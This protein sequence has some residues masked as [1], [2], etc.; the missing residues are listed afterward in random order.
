M[1]AKWMGQ[2]CVSPPYVET[3]NSKLIKRFCTW[4]RGR[5]AFSNSE[6][7]M[8]IICL[9]RTWPY[10]CI[11]LCNRGKIFSSLVILRENHLK[12][13]QT[14]CNPLIWLWF[15]TNTRNSK[16]DCPVG[17]SCR[18]Y[19]LLLYR[20]VRHPVNECPGY[21]T[22]QSDGETPVIQELW[23]MWNTHHRHRS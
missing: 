9:F 2:H 13:S 21:D 5:Y 6:I 7:P 17:W 8:F 11:W 4:T 1:G 16:N 10:S 3:F 20:G 22:K 12:L 18:I 15:I 19:Q 14:R 23:G